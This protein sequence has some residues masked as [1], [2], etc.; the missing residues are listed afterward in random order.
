MEKYFFKNWHEKGI[1]VIFDI[2]GQNGEIYTFEQLK[3]M[4]NII[5]TFLDY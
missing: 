4:Y 2:I 5:D 1:R 3:T